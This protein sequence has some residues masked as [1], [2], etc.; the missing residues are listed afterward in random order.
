MIE[1]VN[2][3]KEF[4]D[5]KVLHDISFTIN[6]NE[7]VAIIGASGCGKTTTLKMINR[8]IVPTKGKILI[9]G[10][11]IEEID[12]TEL[13]RSIGYVIQQMGLFPH[14]TVKENI[15]LIQKL[16]KKDPKEIEENTNRL[17]EIMDLDGDLYLNKYPS[18]LSGGQQQRVGVAR[19][20]ANN[21]KVILM[22]EPFSALDPITRSN[23]QDELVELHKKMNTTIVFVTHDMDEAIK[24]ADR[25]IIMKDGDIVQY[26]TPEEILKH[27]KNE[28]VQEFIG[29]NKIWDAP[30]YIKV[31]DIMITTPIV[32]SPDL[33]KNECVKKMVQHHIDTL[34]VVD[35]D[36]RYIGIVN[37][38]GLYSTVL[39]WTNAKDMVNENAITASPDESILELLQYIEETDVT[40]IPVVDNNG[41]LKGLITSSSLISVLSS[42]YLDEYESGK[43]DEA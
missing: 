10:K 5:K 38:K 18:D 33:T 13:R 19:A 14:M 21:P 32:C 35:E 9:D 16:E 28:F 20:L 15:E 23:L 42:P 11:N 17:M 25:I 24:I 40:N 8:L 39:P 3:S 1:F 26:D 12:K 6:D 36:G 30:E 2:V 22:D 34:I 43:E 37:R 4:K 29:K 7:L 27:P 31:E 41:Y